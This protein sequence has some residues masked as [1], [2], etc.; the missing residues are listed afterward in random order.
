MRG[1]LGRNTFLGLYLLRQQCYLAPMQAQ[2]DTAPARTMPELAII[3]AMTRNLVIGSAGRL[4]WHLREDLQLFRRLTWGSTLIMGRKTYASIGRPLPGRV[5]IVLSRTRHEAA[6]VHCCDSFMAGLTVAA[7]LGR[8]VFVIGGAQLYR[9]ALPIAA[10]LHVSWVK[11]E[12]A[13]D[14]HFPALDFTT[15]SCC[16]EQEYQGFRYAH[17][18]RTGGGKST[19]SV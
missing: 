1:T 17:Y 5:S 3:V 18:C 6:G 19:H 13:G 7:R 10:Q 9:K 11:G 15:W 16:E 4:P 12:Y 14:V 8:P 2:D